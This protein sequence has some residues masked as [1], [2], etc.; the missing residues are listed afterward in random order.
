[1]NNLTRNVSGR[2]RIL[3]IAGVLFFYFFNPQSFVSNYLHTNVV[4]SFSFPSGSMEPTIMKGDRI[5][6]DKAAYKTSEPERGDIIVFLYPQDS[7][8]TFLKRLIASGGET[9]EIKNGD[10][11]VNDELV[12]RSSIKN[13]HYYNRGD[14]G[15][16]GKKI[17]IP[18]GQVYVLGEN[19]AASHD[20]RYWGFVPREHILGKV[21]KIYYPFDRSGPIQ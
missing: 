9:V 10:V 19:S 17:T 1:M 12:Q 16:A 2:K 3:L 6:V 14:Y 18:E 7:T 8:R 21:F 5:L 15:Q 13:I 11:Y 20:S 4:Q